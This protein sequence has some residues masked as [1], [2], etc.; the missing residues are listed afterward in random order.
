LMLRGGM[1]QLRLS[2]QVS[3]LC[4]IPAP[5]CLGVRA[6]ANKEQ[7]QRGSQCRSQGLQDPKPHPRVGEALAGKAPTGVEM[8]DRSL[9][10]QAVR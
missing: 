4:S 5:V 2:F 6:D 1:P 7:I 10:S 3:T 8:E 9:D